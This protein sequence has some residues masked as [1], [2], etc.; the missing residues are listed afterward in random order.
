MSGKNDFQE[1]EYYAAPKEEEYYAAPKVV[2][3]V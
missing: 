3:L 2:R 1:E